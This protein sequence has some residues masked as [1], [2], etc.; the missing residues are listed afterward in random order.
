MK[1]FRYFGASC[2]SLTF[3][4]HQLDLQAVPTFRSRISTL[5]LSRAAA[6]CVVPGDSGRSPGPGLPQKTWNAPDRSSHP[7]ANTAISRPRSQ[8]LSGPARR[9]HLFECRRIDLVV[10]I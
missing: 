4:L 8:S 2:L 3:G 5:A 1:Y 6:K 10:G 9:E 7:H